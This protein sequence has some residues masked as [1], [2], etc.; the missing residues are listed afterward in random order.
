MT[1]TIGIDA[2]GTKLRC[3][4]IVGSWLGHGTADLAAILDPACF[5]IG[6]GVSDA[7]DMLPDRA[8]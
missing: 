7:G 3:F 1:L 2:E 5:V 8:R 4:E 6:G